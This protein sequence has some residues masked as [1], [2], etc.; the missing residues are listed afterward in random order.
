MRE[1]LGE[2]IIDRQLV[3]FERDAENGE[4]IEASEV[5]F[6]DGG[7]IGRRE[8]REWEAEEF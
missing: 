2:S 5:F 8:V 4:M 7:E 6:E 3:D 1:E